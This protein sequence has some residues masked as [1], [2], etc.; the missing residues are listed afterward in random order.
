M[1]K[2]IT[3]HGANARRV[4]ISLCDYSGRWAQ[5]WADAGHTVLLYDLKHGDD[6]TQLGAF[7]IIGV[8]TLPGPFAVYSQALVDV[9]LAA[10]PCT[11]FAVSGARWWAAKDA[12]GTTQQSLR[13]LDACLDIIAGLA[14]RVWALENPVGRINKLRPA[15]GKPVFWFHPHEY[16]A[17][18][19]DPASEAY[20]KKTG[21][22]GN[23]RNPRAVGIDDYSLPPVMYERG[24]KRGSWMW[25]NLGGKSERTKTL[26]SNTPQGFARRFY[27]ANA[28]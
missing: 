5:P 10:P 26:R 24:G 21:I 18:A 15:L 23:A 22:W 28:S 19:D 8:H 1:P 13:V 7:D 3:G 14:P 16:A 9:V 2:I 12:D 17:A 25:A 4:V 11:D 6:L 27:A 20:T